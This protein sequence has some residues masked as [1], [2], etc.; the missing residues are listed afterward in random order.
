MISLIRAVISGIR[1]IE[2]DMSNEYEWSQVGSILVI[3]PIEEWAAR[4]AR[5]ISA[6]LVNALAL[7]QRASLALPGGGTPVPVFCA[8]ANAHEQALD[9]SRVDVFLGDERCVNPD[10]PDSNARNI[11]RELLDAFTKNKP[12]LHLPDGIASDPDAA[13]ARYA[14]LVPDQ[15]DVLVGGM[16][17]DG[18]TASLFPG[19]I[20]SVEPGPRVVAIHDSPKPPPQRITLSAHAHMSARN[21]LML[22]RGA[23]KAAAVSRAL[24]NSWEPAACPA[25]LLRNGRWLLDEA[26]ASE[27]E[28]RVLVEYAPTEIEEGN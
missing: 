5:F 10:H 3:D 20:G 6:Q 13:A 17:P 26:A 2:V 19:A 16:G 27:L 12:V 4:G 9:W 21:S 14:E 22:V 7:R 11:R 23:D 18:H 15:I 8:L 24:L 25:Q 28:A 1:S